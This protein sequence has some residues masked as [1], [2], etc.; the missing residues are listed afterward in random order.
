MIPKISIITPSYNQGKFLEQTILSVLGQNY[1]NTEY[2]II[3]GGS[4]DNSVDIIRKYESRLA[5]WV[6]EKDSG[7]ANAINKGFAKATGDIL[8]WLNSDDMFMPGIF[9]FVVS[10]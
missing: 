4:S 7:Q 5:F 3:D 6:S 1:S 9:D 2:I 10:E 8:C